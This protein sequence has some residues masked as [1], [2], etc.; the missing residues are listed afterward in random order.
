[1]GSSSSGR[2][3]TRNRGTVDAALRLD[4][5]VMR[6]QGFLVP[7]TVTSGVQRWTRVAT[8]EESGAVNVTVNLT[9]PERGFVVIRFTLD[10]D[11]SEQEIRLAS[12]P[13]RYGGRRYYFICP[14]HGRRCEVMPVVGGV[15]ASRQ[16]GRLNY[17]SQSNAP[18]DRMQAK[19]WALEKRLWPGRG[20][21]GPRGRN[22]ER[23]LAEWERADTA[24]ET[25]FAAT[26]MHRWG[27]LL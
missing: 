17:Q 11:L 4:L 8:G 25:G 6:R 20:K 16:A 23:L 21:P 27:G 13:M 5:R 15:F 19:A 10:G 7:G 26:M 14:K 1:M 22:R 18:L 3:R 9:D 24:F 12:L 2:Y